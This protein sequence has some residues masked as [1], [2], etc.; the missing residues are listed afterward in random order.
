MHTRT[1]ACPLNFAGM[2]GYGIAK[3]ATHHLVRSLAAGGLP[4]ESVVAGVLPV[5][6]DTRMP[7]TLFNALAC[8]TLHSAES[9]WHAERRLLCVDASW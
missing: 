8:L 1:H 3:A 9:C 2:I 7:K 6:L 4:A 5:T